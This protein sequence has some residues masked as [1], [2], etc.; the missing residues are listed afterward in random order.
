MRELVAVRWA[1]RDAQQE[2]GKGGA[3]RADSPVTL[4]TRVDT[5]KRRRR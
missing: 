2:S 1:G 3:L 4:E 5:T